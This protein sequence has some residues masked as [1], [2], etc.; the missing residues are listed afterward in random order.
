MAAAAAMSGSAR[1]RCQKELPPSLDTF[2]WCTWDAF[3]STVSAQGLR[4]GLESLHNNGIRPGFL[5]ID[6]GWQMTDVDRDSPYSK[7]LT[8]QLADKL[9]LTD[10]DKQLL[11][12]TDDDFFESGTKFVADSARKVVTHEGTS[13]S[14]AMRKL[15]GARLRV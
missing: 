3:Y 1:P 4:Q 2:G 9:P 8:S 7:S 5:I 6:D 14:G 12:E 11:A 13:T 10:S 15:A